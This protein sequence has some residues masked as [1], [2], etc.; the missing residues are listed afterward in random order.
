MPARA[1][2]LDGL[3]LGWRRARRRAALATAPPD[4]PDPASLPPLPR[5]QLL[6][7]LVG[8]PVL[9]GFVMAVLKKR[10]YAS[11]EESLLTAHFDA[12]SGPSIK[13]LDFETLGD[14][15]G[16]VPTAKIGD[17]DFSRLILGGNLMNGFAHARDLIYV[18]KLIKAYHYP[19]RVY[20]TFAL[21]EQ[22]GVNAVLT[23]P[24][25]APRITEY[26]QKRGG[27]IKFIAQCK[28]NTEKE[29]MERVEYSID[30]GACAAYIQGNSA[31]TYV[32]NGQFDWIA[33]ALERIRQAGLPAGI[34]AHYIQTIQGCVE[35]GFEPD[36]WMKTLH[37]DRYWSATPKDRRRE[38]C[39]DG[40]MELDHNEFHDNIWCA[41]AETTIAFMESLPQPWIAYKVLAAG[42]IEPKDGFRYAF[43][44]GADF[45]CV[46]MYDFQVVTDANIALDVLGNR[47]KLARRRRWYA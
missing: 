33:R 5:R 12:L 43:E 16:K 40:K 24:I 44:Q 6:A 26:W 41:D 34:G 36:F 35:Q 9:G 17:V 42:S 30:Q 29:L 21:A 45:I 47:Q 22:C 31:D 2:G 28:G 37:H 3:L 23:N 25:L 10:G 13:N 11:Q 32:R 7:G 4:R 20:D 14:L 1:L 18:E 19:E 46:G 39:I 27:Q 15:K 38:Y 8:L